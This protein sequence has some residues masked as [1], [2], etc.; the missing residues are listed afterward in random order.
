MSESTLTNRAD[1]RLSFRG[2][3]QVIVRVVT[4]M[5]FFKARVAAV[6]GLMTL[7]HCF[8]MLLLPWA[9]TIIVDHVILGQPIDDTAS[10]FPGYLAPLVLPLRGMNPADIM[11]W[12]LMVGL[13]SVILFGMTPNRATG[14][15]A[16]G[17]LSGASAGSQG[18]ASATLA[19]G[20]DTATQSENAANSGGDAGGAGGSVYGAQAPMAGSAMGGLLG[21]LDFKIHM[22]LTQSVNHMLRTRLAEH[23]LS[24]PVITLD[25]QR[26]GDSTYR[27][28]YDSTSVTGVYEALVVGIYPGLL[29][30]ALTLGIMLTSF[31]AAP[32]VIVAGILVG[33]LTFLFVTP[34][35]RLAR[36]RS[37]ASR[38]AGSK[39]TSNI[40]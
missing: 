16:S 21:I 35:A 6:I 20:Q 5:R 30:V 37:E 33:P 28:M 18:I 39:T 22:R 11:F 23:V 32:D 9:L 1:D 40:E 19:E 10:E 27:V 29:A 38:F 25:D 4:L 8:R 24:L 15:N 12:M 17:T 31:D 13:G 26:I 14:R 34:F 7:E 2:A 3:L 36:R